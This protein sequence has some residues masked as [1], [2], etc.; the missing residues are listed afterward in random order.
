MLEPSLDEARRG[1]GLTITELWLRYLALGGDRTPVELEAHLRGALELDARE[2]RR[3][4]HAI[5]E[6]GGPPAGDGT[7]TAGGS[8]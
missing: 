7:A 1:A 4:A 2:R 5:A 8:G 3:I 6:A